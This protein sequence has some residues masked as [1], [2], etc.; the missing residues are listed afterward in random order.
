M[1]QD[2][3]T[4]LKA[5]KECEL[6]CL[7][8]KA[9]IEAAK[10]YKAKECFVNHAVGVIDDEYSEDITEKDI[11]NEVIRDLS[12]NGYLVYVRRHSIWPNCYSISIYWG[13]GFWKKQFYKIMRYIWGKA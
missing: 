1:N 10:K 4:S 11:V 9:N 5:L 6:L 3:L 2:I 13:K 8:V 12:L 7:K